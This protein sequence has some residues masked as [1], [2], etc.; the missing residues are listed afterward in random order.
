MVVT[1]PTLSLKDSAVARTFAGLWGT[2]GRENPNSMSVAIMFTNKF[3]VKEGSIIDC[4][5]AYSI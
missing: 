3:T 2:S 1:A 5:T 4:S